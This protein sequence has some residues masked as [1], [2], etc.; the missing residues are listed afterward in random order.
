MSDLNQ[1]LRF[2]VNDE[3]A[4]LLALNRED[5]ITPA[6]MQR[7]DFLLTARGQQIEAHIHALH[8]H[9]NYAA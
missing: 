6:Q 5:E 3:L 1:Q 4:L 2:A 8:Y 7:L 9:D